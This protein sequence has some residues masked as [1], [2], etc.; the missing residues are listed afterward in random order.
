MNPLC[1]ILL[2]QDGTQVIAE[3]AAP[4]PKLRSFMVAKFAMTLNKKKWSSTLDRF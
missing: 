1:T 3:V 2:H 4:P